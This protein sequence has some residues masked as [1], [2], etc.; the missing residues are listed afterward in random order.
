M[1]DEEQHSS[2]GQSN[3]SPRTGVHLLLQLPRGMGQD[4]LQWAPGIVTPESTVFSQGG[5]RG[6]T[7]QGKCQKASEQV[8][9]C[10]SSFCLAPGAR[11]MGCGD[12]ASEKSGSISNCSVFRAKHSISGGQPRSQQLP[13]PPSWRMFHQA[14]FVGGELWRQATTPGL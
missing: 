10:V 13:G 14:L 5:G 4:A 11:Q 6:S 2:S 9:R 12:E 3:H 8:D 1:G 7:R